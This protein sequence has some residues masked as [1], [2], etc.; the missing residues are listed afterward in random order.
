MSGFPNLSNI[1]E[2]ISSTILSKANSN[3]ANSSKLPWFRVTTLNGG[4]GLIIDSLNSRE[5]FT[6][7][8]GN[9]TQAGMVGFRADYST[10]V[11]AGIDP[12][13]QGFVSPEKRGLRPSP[14][15]ENV[16][17]QNG[18]EG[19]T[20][21]VNFTIKCYTLSQTEVI[22]Q[23]FLEPGSY[24]L[25]EFGWNVPKSLAER[26]GGGGPVTVCEMVNYTNL[27]ILKDKRAMSE[28]TYDAV[29]AVVTGGGV[30]Y[31]EG[32]T[33]N[34]EIEL[35]SQGELPAYL[36]SQKGQILGVEDIASGVKFVQG[37]LDAAEDEENGDVGKFL[38]MQMYN[39][40]PLQ[41]QIGPVKQLQF[42]TDSNG[43]PWTDAANFLNMDVVVREDLVE[44]A[45]NVKLI[46]AEAEDD[47]ATLKVPEDIPLVSSE[48]FIRFELAYKI[49]QTQ[50]NQS[51]DMETGCPE[52]TLRD[53]LAKKIKTHRLN[54]ISIDNTMCRA[55]RH[56][57]STDKSKL[58]IPNTELPDFQLIDALKATPVPSSSLD[59]LVET[60]TFETINA[61]PKQDYK[62][63]G[64]GNQ[65]AVTITDN[66]D[67]TKYAF[68]STVQGPTLDYSW[69][70]TII[71]PDAKPYKHGMLKN[72]YINFDFFLQIIQSPG[73]YEHEALMEMLNGMSSAVNFHWDFQIIET[74]QPGT[75]SSMLQV[76]DKSYVGTSVEGLKLDKD[77]IPDVVK[78][79]F[80]TQGIQSPFINF[81]L[82][83][84]IP[85]AM[86]NQVMAQKNNS[87]P[88]DGSEV[89]NVNLAG[90]TSLETK[91]INFDTGL[92]SPFPDPVSQAMDMISTFTSA[93]LS[94]QQAVRESATQEA[95]KANKSSRN[96]RSILTDGAK[97]VW[98]GVKSVASATSDLAAYAWTGDTKSERETRKANYKYFIEK[99][100]VFP[101]VNDRNQD[102]DIANEKFDFWGANNASIEG[103]IFVGTWNDPHLLKK[104]ELYSLIE[105]SGEGNGEVG[106]DDSD[107][108][109][110]PPLL[111]IEFEFTIHGVSG[112][113]VGD[114][115]RVVDLP[116]KFADKIFQITEINHEVGEIWTTKVK[117]GMRNI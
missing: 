43:N 111:P 68:P 15:I 71:P 33:F 31:G 39:Q 79:K 27:G 110:N 55:F 81:D 83:V 65:D 64:S 59:P 106:V 69:D 20:R 17:I 114:I 45:K 94:E 87:A 57:F 14:S 84:D 82:K 35:T 103:V 75:G 11:Y 86:M 73:L 4:G 40:L 117:A 109:T 105:E 96:W 102:Y 28:G 51:K 25:M 50:G 9:L 16:S 34:V 6:R 92:F 107:F 78:T 80:Y 42:Q 62:I 30:N 38:F 60:P 52:Y 1:E 3:Y 67:L 72:L 61:H 23:H 104:Y 112:L 10:P 113:K 19:L 99:A 98:S 8:Y 97:T 41:K 116:Y 49:L 56:M 46:S 95:E 91:A 48:R 70:T 90:F 37:E 53:G 66:S 24:V 108:I 58:F 101:K 74:G 21:K 5:N 36:R 100:G 93:S 7:K 44:S 76:V 2:R 47:G 29:L 115:F 18:T 88:T 54:K 63:E 89:P 12:N 26:A 13:E 32:E 22:A 85:G 77:G